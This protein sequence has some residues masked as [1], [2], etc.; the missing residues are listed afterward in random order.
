MR[1]ILQVILEDKLPWLKDV[2][3]QQEHKEVAQCDQ[4]QDR[5]P[6]ERESFVRAYQRYLQLRCQIDNL[7]IQL[8]NRGILWM[9]VGVLEIIEKLNRLRK[10]HVIQ[11]AEMVQ[12]AIRWVRTQNN[13]TTYIYREARIGNEE[14]ISAPYG[15]ALHE[16]VEEL[17]TKEITQHERSCS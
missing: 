7:E 9:S 12:R 8:E 11:I 15:A 6:R 5:D 14:S 17:A 3:P 2:S 16:P 13:V 1:D 4:I 10:L